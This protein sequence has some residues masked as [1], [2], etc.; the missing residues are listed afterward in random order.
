MMITKTATRTGL[1]KYELQKYKKI[2][3]S[4]GS[5]SYL[6]GIVFCVQYDSCSWML[7]LFQILKYT[8]ITD[9]F[10]F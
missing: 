9:R 1:K 2:N 8:K 4:I 5:Q 7:N 6:Y 3:I 10:Q